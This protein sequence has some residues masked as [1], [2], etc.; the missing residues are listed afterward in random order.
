V[1][2]ALLVACGGD[3]A[4]EST[5]T[6]SDDTAVAFCQ[7]MEQSDDLEPD[8]GET[9]DELRAKLDEFR[10]L[11]LRIAE[12]APD[13]IHAEVEDSV[14]AYSRLIDLTAS[15][16]YNLEQVDAASV[17]ELSGEIDAN[18]DVIQAWLES[19]CD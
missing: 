19:N 12:R 3:D 6:L 5:T 4:S 13:E 9:P 17:S 11:L 15:A 7:L 2:V 18:G 16:D 1:T 8:G 10:T 14:S